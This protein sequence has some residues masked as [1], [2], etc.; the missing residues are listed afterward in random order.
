MKAITLL[1]CSLAANALFAYAHWARAHRTPE[2]PATATAPA[3]VIKGAGA[4]APKTGWAGSSGPAAGS[5]THAAGIEGIVPTVVKIDEPL[6]AALQSR[7][8]RRL[9]AALRD[10]G[11]PE[12]FIRDIMIWE[13]GNMKLAERNALLD[14]AAKRPFWQTQTR[15]ERQAWENAVD[16]T[17]AKNL[18]ITKEVFGGFVPPLPQ[19]TLE[20]RRYGFL[21]E[22]KIELIADMD[23]D[24]ATLQRDAARNGGFNS[25]KYQQIERERRTELAKLL[26]P[27]ELKQ[28]DLYLSPAAEALRRQMP[29]FQPTE[30]EFLAM[31]DARRG[32][33]QKAGANGPLDGLRPSLSDATES[34]VKDQFRAILGD[35]RYAE[36]LR[37]QDFGYRTA[38]AITSHFNL[39]PENAAA[40]YQLQQTTQ[41]R[42][43]ELAAQPG[44]DPQAVRAAL[45]SVTDE[46][47]ARLEGLLGK[48]GADAYR[49]SS[50][51]AWLRPSAAPG[52]TVRRSSRP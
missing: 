41:A 22:D 4:R 13:L 35:E 15:A 38:V 34:P 14:A 48:S 33:D 26:S 28:Y 42:S 37:G 52:V 8:P 49:A 12:K 25:E 18:A 40:T 45:Q 44:S 30:Q 11:F 43:R 27:D 32:F 16:A 23:S 20:H 17:D 9:L 3:A 29:V 50:G 7:D 24:Y 51:G 31:L 21:P 2:R 46:A 1:V 6:R 47:N 36:F 5:E 10:N 39:P 19:L